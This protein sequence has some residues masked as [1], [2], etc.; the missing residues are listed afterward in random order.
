MPS[1]ILESVAKATEPFIPYLTSRKAGDSAP[2]FEAG[3]PMEKLV[4]SGGGSYDPAKYAVNPINI[5]MFD[6]AKQA[7]ANWSESGKLPSVDKVFSKVP[8]IKVN[9]GESNVTR[10]SDAGAIRSVLPL[11]P[12]IQMTAAEKAKLVAAI[13]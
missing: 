1:Q 4:Q 12:D 3:G 9:P 6:L 2:G 11:P 7:G 10:L 8:D 13:A 5:N